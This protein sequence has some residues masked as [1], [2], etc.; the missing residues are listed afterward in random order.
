MSHNIAILITPTPND[1]AGSA[2]AHD[3]SVAII[4]MLNANPSLSHHS[5][6]VRVAGVSLNV[7]MEG[8]IPNPT[9]NHLE[10]NNEQLRHE[11]EMAASA[12]AAPLYPPV[13][14]AADTYQALDELIQQA[15][16]RALTDP[17]REQLRR[18]RSLTR[19]GSMLTTEHGARGVV[20]AIVP[21]DADP[22]AYLDQVQKVVATPET[23]YGVE[24]VSYDE[25][26]REHN[27]KR[28]E[29]TRQEKHDEVVA[30]IPAVTLL[31]NSEAAA[32]YRHFDKKGNKLVLSF[33]PIV[34]ETAK[35]TLDDLKA[36]ADAPGGLTPLQAAHRENLETAV[37]IADGVALHEAAYTATKDETQPVQKTELDS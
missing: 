25:S 10:A 9:L 4:G 12:P 24:H 32:A 26:V 15:E 20:C 36:L 31:I 35:L 6:K 14:Q 27:R 22:S 2:I 28:E 19:F 7:A 17:E 11:K 18:L 34:L 8:P 33:D 16:L 3:I 1:T 23:A 29:R 13:A 30:E 37:E 5:Y 21:D